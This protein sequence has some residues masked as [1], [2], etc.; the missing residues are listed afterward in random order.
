MGVYMIKDLLFRAEKATLYKN[1]MEKPLDNP[2]LLLNDIL[3]YAYVSSSFKELEP[4]NAYNLTKS[5]IW[6]ELDMG[7]LVSHE[8]YKF[9]KLLISIKPKYTW[10]SCMRYYDGHY[11]GKCFNI[12]LSTNT[13][14][15]FK[16][17][18]TNY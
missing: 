9:E 15:I 12:N 17:L 7:K 8:G 18:N 16:L 5:G 2:Q 3:D 10:L 11:Q 1:G 14:N 4:T 13:T 6:L